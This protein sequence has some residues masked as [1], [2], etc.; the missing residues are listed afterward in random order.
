M[1][2]GENARKV[3]RDRHDDEA[4]KRGERRKLG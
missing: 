3:D 2:I 1:G 4:G